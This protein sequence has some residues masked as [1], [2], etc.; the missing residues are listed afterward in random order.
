MSQAKQVKMKVDFE[1]PK[2]VG[3]I[4]DGNGRWAQRQGKAR[5]FGH[6]AGMNRLKGIVKTASDIGIS[7]LSLYAFSTEN[8]RRPKAEIEALM[9]LLLE[10]FN[11]EIDELHENNV[12]IRHLGELSGFSDSVRKA[13]INA[14]E[15]T[16]NNT[17]LQ[18]CIALNYGSR[19][20]ITNA[21]KAIAKEVKEN[22]LDIDD[23]DEKLISSYL[24]T[25]DLPELDLIMRT[26]GEQRLSNFLMYQAAYA[27]LV[28]V[29][30]TW[31]E[32]SDELFIQ[33]LREYSERNRRFGGL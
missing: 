31:P 4:M 23:I 15:R 18:L 6:R 25:K 10:Y 22:S 26:S 8:W 3:I 33:T 9:G 30:E 24:Y 20:E 21:V 16:K 19:L 2:H 11:K 28:F 13:I 29:K 5:V 32:F 1:I 27:E 17:G 14:I 7:A 12:K